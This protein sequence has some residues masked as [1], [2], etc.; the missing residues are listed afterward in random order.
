MT[1]LNDDG[2]IRDPQAVLAA[3]ERYKQE[4]QKNRE[5]RDIAQQR[6]SELESDE[7]ANKF[8]ERMVQTEAKS[9]L[10]AL[11][12][13]EPERLVKYIDTKTIELDGDEIKGLDEAISGVRTDFP[14]L[15]DVKKRA[16][17]IERTNDE[18]TTQRSTSELQAAKM[19]GKTA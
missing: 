5:E 14:E 13:K 12:I 3:L 10:M 11:G 2:T 6:V 15:F 17:G 9:R 18:N 7:T 1:D 19:L 4:A 16:G 8:K